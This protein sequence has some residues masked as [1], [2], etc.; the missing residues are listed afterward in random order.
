MVEAIVIIAWRNDVGAYLL[1]SYPEGIDIDGQDLMNL[2][3]LHRFRDTKANFQFITTSTMRIASFYSGGYDNPYVGRPNYAVALVLSR[4]EKPTDYEK[5]LRVITNNLL[6]HLEDENFDEYLENIFKMIK[7]GRANEIKIE[8]R[9][10]TNVKPKRIETTE[11]IKDHIK[12]S[13]EQDIFDELLATVAD[14]EVPEDLKFDEDAFRKEL[15]SQKSMDPFG[16]SASTKA[17]A[18]PFSGGSA[19]S[20]D[21]FSTTS[22]PFAKLTTETPKPAEKPS[23][24]APKISKILNDLNAL[25]NKM[26]SPPA[27]KS[28]EKMVQYLEQKVGYL[29]KKLSIVSQIATLLQ[30][31]ERELDEKNELISKL[32]ILLS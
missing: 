26:P 27:D 16:S 28:P 2:Y 32:L 10:V 6:I 4:N 17:A 25:D 15:E 20:G 7:A 29:E 14:E 31:K 5:A 1:D 12:T 8:R 21:L 11:T 24:T 9:R 23:I 30:S 3:N 19:S 22:D 13:E 18:D